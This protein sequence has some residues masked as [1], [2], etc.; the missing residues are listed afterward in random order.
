MNINW[1]I[2]VK[3]PTFWIGIVVSIF[4][5]IFAYTG[6]SAQDITSW[7]TLL[8]LILNAVKNPY[9]LL[10]IA[11]SVYNTIVD[12]TTTGLTDSSRALQYSYPNNIKD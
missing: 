6:L 12:P 5:P 4:V 9:V 1:T 11:G 2:R 10:M 8:N 7:G 3:N